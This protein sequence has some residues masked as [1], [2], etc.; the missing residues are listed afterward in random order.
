MSRAGALGAWVLAAISVATADVDP[1][2]RAVV[3]AGAWVLL[4]RR[5][6]PGRRLRPLGIGLVVAAL[7]A[8]PIN[9]LLVHTGAN[10]LVSM[11]AWLPG[12][13]GPITLEAFADGG[14][15]AL[16][17][18]AAVSAAAALSLVVDPADLVD[19]LPGPLARTGVVLGAALNLVPTV[20]ASARTIS[21]AQRTR[22]WRPRGARGLADLVVPVLLDTIERSVT[23][24]ESMQSRGFGAGRRTS[25]RAV[26][27]RRADLL[28]GI[29][30][31]GVIAGLVAG[32]LS[33]ASGSWDPYPTLT[34]PSGSPALLVPAVALAVL[35]WWVTPAPAE[36]SALGTPA[37]VALGPGAAAVVALGPG[38]AAPEGLGPGAAAGEAAG[39]AVGE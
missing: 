6:L 19:A 27:S 17:L 23:L 2:P 12:I 7:S 1:L 3:L 35:G 16:G 25:A 22:G 38:A 13:G 21:E 32:H 5:R 15:V 37:P 4:A 30:A 11:P 24:A 10:V 31:L 39:E 26:V 18:A 36:A 33:G 29:G 28:V 14:G 34:V 8:V 20:A 9:G